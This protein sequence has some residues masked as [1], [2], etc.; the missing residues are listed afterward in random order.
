MPEDDALLAAAMEGTEELNRRYEGS[1]F[2]LFYRRRRWSESEQVWMGWERKRGKLEELNRLLAG[3]NV[4]MAGRSADQQEATLQHVGDS[5]QL[6]GVRFV[7][8]LDA[9]TQLPRDAAQRMIA[10]LAHPLNRP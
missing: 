2:S 7:I 4:A 6:N 10:T 3:D 8:T 9:D 1:P 5:A